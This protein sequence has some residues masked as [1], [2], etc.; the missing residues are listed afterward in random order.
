MASGSSERTPLLG[1]VQDAHVVP[2][3][4]NG[5][6]NHT[7][8]DRNDASNSWFRRLAVPL[9]NRLKVDVENRIL[10]AGFLITLSF[11]FTQVP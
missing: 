1:G 10:F 7:T 4:P 3:I 8:R 9:R 11:S 6:S 2:A 5:Q